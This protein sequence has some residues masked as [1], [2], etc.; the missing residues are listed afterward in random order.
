MPACC[1]TEKSR[2]PTAAALWGALGDAAAV[3]HEFNAYL[4]DLFDP[5]SRDWKFMQSGWVLVTKRRTRTVCYLFPADG[6]FT[7]AFVFGEK[8]VAAAR[9]AKLPSRIKNSIEAARPYAEGRGFYVKVAKPADL[10][11]LETLAT[12]K[13]ST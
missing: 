11:H 9:K 13:L 7:V 8:A 4:D 3:W 5:I 2:K 1:F 12:I 6:H 10:T